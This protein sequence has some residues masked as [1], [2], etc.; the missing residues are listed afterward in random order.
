MMGEVI[1]FQG[2]EYIVVRD[3][4]PDEKLAYRE[5]PHGQIEMLEMFGYE[6]KTTK[7]SAAFVQWILDH[8]IMMER[9][10]I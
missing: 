6:V 9:R 1:V 10:K 2:E 4:L 8:K 3:W 7:F 5:L